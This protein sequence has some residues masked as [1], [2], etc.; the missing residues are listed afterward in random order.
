LL[1]HLYLQEVE[2]VPTGIST[3]ATIAPDT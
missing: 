2:D 3:N 1:D